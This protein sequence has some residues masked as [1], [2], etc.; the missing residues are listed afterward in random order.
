MS[1]IVSSVRPGK[2][3]A[4]VGMIFSSS[5]GAGFSLSLGSFIGFFSA[6]SLTGFSFTFLLAFSAFAAAFF[7]AFACFLACFFDFL[8]FFSFSCFSASCAARIS[9]S[10][11]VAL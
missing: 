5:T 6:F 9:S 3:T 10:V 8:E 11:R 4:S 2:V 7:S 1:G